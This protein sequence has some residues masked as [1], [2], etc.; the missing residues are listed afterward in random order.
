MNYRHYENGRQAKVAQVEGLTF[1][2]V[3]IGGGREE[4]V[5]GSSWNI[6][7]IRS[8]I[9]NNVL[10]RIVNYTS[11]LF[12]FWWERP[13]KCI[14]NTET[15]KKRIRINLELKTVLHTSLVETNYK[16]EGCSWGWGTVRGRQKRFPRNISRDSAA[17]K[18]INQTPFPFKL[19][20]LEDQIQIQLFGV[21][22]QIL[23]VLLCCTPIPTV[24]CLFLWDQNMLESDITYLFNSCGQYQCRESLTE[25]DLGVFIVIYLRENE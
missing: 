1:M 20:S 2:R 24:H 5:M 21:M 9:C 14:K 11:S 17:T 10:V 18:Q 6:C 19:Q 22:I 3:W 25:A 23:T 13:N 7:S 12:R 16:L 15:N 4:G 8:F